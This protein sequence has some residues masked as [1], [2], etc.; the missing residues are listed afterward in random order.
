MDF[1][2]TLNW[3]NAEEIPD[4]HIIPDIYGLDT[5]GVR[6][7]LREAGDAERALRCVS[8]EILAMTDEDLG[9]A[10][11]AVLRAVGDLAA[12]SEAVLETRAVRLAPPR[13]VP[14][15]L[16]ERLGRDLSSAG[17]E[18]SYA[19]AWSATNGADLG[20]GSDGMR[21][22]LEDFLACGTGWRVSDASRRA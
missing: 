10:L 3:R 4:N 15:R 18:V 8:G 5:C 22:E 6:S 14:G 13:E 9:A 20:V 12:L 17:F 16:V 21:A 1:K 11:D 7:T 19:P 2:A